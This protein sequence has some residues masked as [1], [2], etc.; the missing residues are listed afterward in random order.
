[1]Q[2]QETPEKLPQFTETFWADAAEFKKK[3]IYDNHILAHELQ[4]KTVDINIRKSENC[5]EIVK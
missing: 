1:M 5:I 4:L 2:L 3:K